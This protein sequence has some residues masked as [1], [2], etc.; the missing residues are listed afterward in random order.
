MTDDAERTLYEPQSISERLRYVA[1][2]YGEVAPLHRLLADAAATIES[3]HAEV[4]SLRALFQQANAA[5]GITDDENPIVKALTEENER[6]RAAAKRLHR[7]DGGGPVLR[8]FL[9]E[10]YESADLERKA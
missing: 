4:R 1:A 7:M 10:F 2:D 3:L 6:L 8:R 5:N 9:D